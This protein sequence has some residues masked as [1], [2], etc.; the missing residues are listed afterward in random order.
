MKSFLSGVRSFLYDETG[1]DMVEYALLLAF[2]FLAALVA[3]QAI[4]Q[5]IEQMFGDVEDAV[6]G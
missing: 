4:G 5:T 6:G 2:F 3:V 1:Q